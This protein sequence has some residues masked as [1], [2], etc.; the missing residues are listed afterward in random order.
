MPV[1]WRGVRT[2]DRSGSMR[3]S[4]LS[5]SP[6]HSM[7]ELD[8]ALTTARMTAFS[9][10]ASPP[11]AQF[12]LRGIVG[13]A[14]RFRRCLDAERF[15]AAIGAHFGDDG[16]PPAPERL[17]E[18]PIAAA[19]QLELSRHSRTPGSPI[20]LQKCVQ[21][22]GRVFLWHIVPPRRI[23]ASPLNN[24]SKNSISAHHGV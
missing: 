3:P 17:G 19:V 12:A 16:L 7:P 1:T 23:R 6:T 21:R 5:S 9:P 13:C 10:G 4:K 11:P 24:P 18:N 15:A 2:R 20:F 14:A 22:E 8:A